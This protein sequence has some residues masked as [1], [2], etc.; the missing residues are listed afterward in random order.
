MKELNLR[1]RLWNYL[2]YEDYNQ[3]EFNINLQFELKEYRG[4]G[5][6]IKIPRGV[7]TIPQDVFSEYVSVLSGSFTIPDTVTDMK[8][9]KLGDMFLKNDITSIEIDKGNSVYHSAGNCIIETVRKVLLAG[10]STSIIPNDGS[11]EQIDA[12]AFTNCCNLRSIY[13]P[14]SVFYIGSWAFSFCFNLRKIEVDKGNKRFH[15]EGNCLINTASKTLIAG[16]CTSIIPDD[17]SVIRIGLGAFSGGRL[18]KIMIPQGVALIES[19]AFWWCSELENIT[20]PDSVLVIEKCAFS[21]CSALEDITIPDSVEYLGESAF[22]DCK[23][24]K[25][26]KLSSQIKRIEDCTFQYCENLESIEIPEGVKSI[27]MWAFDGCSSLEKI[28]IPSDIKYIEAF[29]F[30]DCQNL[31][32]VT[33]PKSFHDE[34]ELKNIFGCRYKEIDFK[35]V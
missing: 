10:C 1:D 29:A 17:G 35:F 6:N 32:E 23:N 20:I 11:V 24:L 5:E 25:K 18:K 34:R 4:S 27:G 14:A 16:C 9:F 8:N 22:S 30:S 15:S 7:D 21:W 13:I 31:R 2:E 33:M 3:N 19:D 28:V 12:D 26:I